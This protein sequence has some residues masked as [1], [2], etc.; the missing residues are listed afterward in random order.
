MSAMAASKSQQIFRTRKNHTTSYKIFELEAEAQQGISTIAAQ[1]GFCR[2][3]SMAKHHVRGCF[4]HA[5]IKI[6]FQ[7][8]RSSSSHQS[9]PFHMST[10]RPQGYSKSFAHET[11]IPYPTG[12]SS[13]N[14]GLSKGTTTMV[15]GGLC[16]SWLMARHQVRGCRWQNRTSFNDQN[17]RT[18]KVFACST[19]LASPKQ[20]PRASA[21]EHLQCHTG[22]QADHARRQGIRCEAISGRTGVRWLTLW[23]TRSQ[24]TMPGRLC[25]EEFCAAS[26]RLTGARSHNYVRGAATRQLRLIKRIVNQITFARVTFSRCR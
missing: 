10:R 24:Q 14:Q 2:S 25:G 7:T 5:K 23:S 4:W 3:W 18:K 26:G 8:R 20:S 12:P 13:L 15:H 22:D 21:R 19:N 9:L 17:V 11:I 1:R 16:R 6:P